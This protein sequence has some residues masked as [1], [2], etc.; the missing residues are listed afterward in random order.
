[1]QEVVDDLEDVVLADWLGDVGVEAHLDDV[2]VRFDGGD[3]RDLHV[4]FSIPE[5]RQD[6]VAVHTGELA[7]QQ[8]D[9][10]VLAE[11]LEGFRAVVGDPN[12]VRLFEP[13]TVQ[14]CEFGLVL[15]D[16]DNVLV[17]HVKGRTLFLVYPVR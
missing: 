17:T 14:V 6:R 1:V 15:D 10:D 9:L 8:D 2:D 7:V 3:H 13:A 4:G 16:E 5:Q 11:L 12:R